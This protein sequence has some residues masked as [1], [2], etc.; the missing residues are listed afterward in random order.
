MLV[1]FTKRDGGVVFVRAE[2]IRRIE[3]RQRPDPQTGVL[4]GN[5]SALYWLE[6]DSIIQAALQGTAREVFAALADE[7][8]RR[9]EEH[10]RLMASSALTPRGRPR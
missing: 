6:H 4:E 5:G 7:E 10:A 2:D 3:D 9:A 8:R 1:P